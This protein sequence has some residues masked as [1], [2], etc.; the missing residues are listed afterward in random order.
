M[1]MQSSFAAGA[2][3]REIELTEAFTEADFDHF[4]RPG[5]CRICPLSS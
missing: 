5:L 1:G 3:E 2:G 4:P